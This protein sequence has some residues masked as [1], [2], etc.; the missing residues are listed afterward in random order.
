MALRAVALHRDRPD[1]PAIGCR[2]VA[3]AALHDFTAGGRPDTGAVQV[4]LVIEL[5]VGVLGCGLPEPDAIDLILVATLTPDYWMPSTAAL[6]KEAIGN[7]RA[8]AMDVSAACS[9]FVYGVSMADALVRAAPPEPEPIGPLSAEAEAVVKAIDEEARTGHAD[10]FCRWQRLWQ[11][12]GGAVAV[13]LAAASVG[14]GVDQWSEPQ[15]C[16]AAT[17]LGRHQRRV[18][19]QPA[20]PC[21]HCR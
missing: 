18:S 2:L 4:Q 10:G 6:L 13:G 20:V 8:P 15:C 12:H 9:G 3:V 17:V 21:Q 7:V 14:T 1:E 11:E 16:A 5:E 19:G